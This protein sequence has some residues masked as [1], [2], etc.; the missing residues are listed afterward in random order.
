MSN[1]GRRSMIARRF[2]RESGAI[3]GLECPLDGAD[4]K[5]ESVQFSFDI[6]CAALISRD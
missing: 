5:S 4:Q 6:A 3:L 2:A 1:K